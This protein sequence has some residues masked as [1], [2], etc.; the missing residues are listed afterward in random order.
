MRKL[1]KQIELLERMDQ[2]V[3]LKATGRPRELARR[4]NISEATV[5][6]L[7]DTMKELNAP[8]LYDLA[9]QSYVYSEITSFKCGF[10]M[11]ELTSETGKNFSG[12]FSYKNL[13]RI[14]E[15]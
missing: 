11:E 3:R 5:F 9:R 8:I 4:L 2:L 14:L 1:I 6:R 7:I 15:F 12:G 13:K 10:Y